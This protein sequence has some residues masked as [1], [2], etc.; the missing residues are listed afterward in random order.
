MLKNITLSDSYCSDNGFWWFK[1]DFMLKNI[2]LSDSYC[3]K[4]S[5][6]ITDFDDMRV[7]SS[8]KKLCYLIHTVKN[9]NA[10]KK[11][12]STNC[13]YLKRQCHEKSMQFF[14]LTK[15][16][17]IIKQWISNEFLRKI[18]QV[19]TLRRNIA[20]MINQFPVHC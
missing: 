14:Q 4:L 8:W 9:E 2:T 1:S 19:V 15:C 11:K 18:I 20:K 16:C 13:I 17:F 7:I 10:K 12:I 6:A 5:V 3:M